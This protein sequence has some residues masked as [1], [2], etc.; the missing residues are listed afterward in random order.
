MSSLVD[1]F[2]YRE[3]LNGTYK[4]KQKNTQKRTISESYTDDKKPSSNPDDIL[5]SAKNFYTKDKRTKLSLLNFLVKLLTKRKSQ[6]KNFTFARQ[7]LF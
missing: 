2:Y 1:S 3:S 4:I 5:K 7:T 6:I